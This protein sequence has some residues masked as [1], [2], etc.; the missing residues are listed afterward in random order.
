MKRTEAEK[1]AFA[2]TC[3]EIEKQ[4]GD[5]LA[6]I[7]KNLPSYTPRAAWYNLQGKYL[8]RNPLQYTEG[9][10]IDPEERRMNEL[11]ADKSGQL[12]AVLKI[13]EE[14][15]DPIEY[16]A[17]L[18]YKVPTQAWADLRIW[19]RKH[20]PDDL[21]KLPA[22]LKL[23]YTEHGLKSYSGGAK[24]MTVK[25]KPKETVEFNG[26]TYERYTGE[27]TAV[28]EYR[29]K[30]PDYEPPKEVVQVKGKDGRVE[31][32]KLYGDKPSPTCCQPARESGVT[33]DD[34]P[35]EIVGI[36]SN[37]KGYY[38]KSCIENKHLPGTDGQY[39]HLIWRDLATRDERSLGLSVTEWLQLAEE[40]PK[41]MRQLGFMK[42]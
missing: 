17:G 42:P 29:E 34:M 3:L 33:L 2:L 14:H 26:K 36:M 8:S 12:D 40:I 31:N 5:V 1:K 30:K 32:V 18:G 23:Y 38:Q 19:T 25:Q 6:Y 16:L 11:K 28:N 39:V 15:G 9:K 22:N 35:L 10:P 21:K 37:V 7:E 4:G 20:R 27:G 24:A 41:A 13:L